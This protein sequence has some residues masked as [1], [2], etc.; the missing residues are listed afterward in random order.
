MRI[1][2]PSPQTTKGP[3]VEISMTAPGSPPVAA[4]RAAR[5][6][7]ISIANFSFGEV[8]PPDKQK[9]F[10]GLIAMFLALTFVK[11]PAAEDVLRSNTVGV[12][13]DVV[14]N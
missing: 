1:A 14:A 11:S 9:P 4:S 13:L 3:A 5:R 2:L 6:T 7:A 8:N 12:M 10:L